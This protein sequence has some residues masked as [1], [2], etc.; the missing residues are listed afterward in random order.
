MH[1]LFSMAFIG[2][3]DREHCTYSTKSQGIRRTIASCMKNCILSYADS[4]RGTEAERSKA[5]ASSDGYSTCK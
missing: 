5:E 1:T 4:I 2:V 3:I